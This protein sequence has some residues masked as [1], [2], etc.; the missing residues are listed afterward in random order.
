M[1]HISIN[2]GTRRYETEERGFQTILGSRD[3]HVI[4]GSKRRE[5]EWESEVFFFSCFTAL[6]HQMFEPSE[7]CN[8]L[9]CA[10]G[11]RWEESVGDCIRAHDAISRQ[12]AA[13][14]LTLLTYLW[15]KS[16]CGACSFSLPFL[17]FSCSLSLSLSL[18][19]CSLH[20]SC[21]CYPRLWQQTMDPLGWKLGRRLTGEI[22]GVCHWQN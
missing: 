7:C 4:S 22:A 11:Q 6:A 21:P 12:W 1:E 18:S 9:L 15:F 16:H 20:H 3:F 14:T 2:V 10:A 19:S 17:F 8:P 13:C 5:Q